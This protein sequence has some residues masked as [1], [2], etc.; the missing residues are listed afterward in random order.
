MFKMDI[1]DNVNKL[2]EVVCRYSEKLINIVNTKFHRNEYIKTTQYE[3][4]MIK[5]CLRQFKTNTSTHLIWFHRQTV[6]NSQSKDV[7]FQMILII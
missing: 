7:Y 5:K 2:L 3:I 6:S 4:K 1:R